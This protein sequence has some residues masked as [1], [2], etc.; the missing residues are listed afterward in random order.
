MRVVPGDKRAQQVLA[1]VVEGFDP[2]AVAPTLT[3]DSR[4]KSN[5]GTLTLLP[6]HLAG[7]ITTDLCTPG[8]AGDQAAQPL[9]HDMIFSALRIP[10]E[11][12]PSWLTRR[13]GDTTPSPLPCVAAA[14]RAVQAGAPSMNLLISTP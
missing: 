4:P 12:A 8:C 14:G 11:D 9:G 13:A 10:A 7:P 2:A 1:L 5:D 6:Q 3:D